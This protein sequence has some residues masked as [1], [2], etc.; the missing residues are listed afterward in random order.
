M[1][2]Q[3]TLWNV[4]V[5]GAWNLAILTPDGIK[6]RLFDLPENTPIQLEIAIDK[7][8]T[9]RAFYDG[10]TVSPSSRQLDV[11]TQSNDV[12]S[13]EKACKLAQTALTNLP[14]TPVSAAGVNIRYSLTPIPNQLFDLMK[15]SVDDVFSDNGFAITGSSS[16]R[17]LAFEP[18]VVNVEIS[19]D[20]DNNGVLV[21]NFHYATSSAQALT[22]WLDKV[23]EFAA[24]ADDL[25]AALN[26]AVQEGN[27]Q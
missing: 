12:E 5:N 13:L 23:N 24:T 3:P 11:S 27:E 16:S 15:S 20:A 26:L 10:I 21:F 4:V 8:G 18:G 2:V 14:E 22:E 7:P 6:K 25:L 1:S 9:F 17:S 19:Y